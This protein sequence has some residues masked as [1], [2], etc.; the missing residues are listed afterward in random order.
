M[1]EENRFSSKQPE[2]MLQDNWNKDLLSNIKTMFKK[3]FTISILNKTEHTLPKPEFMFK[4]SPW[5]LDP[6]QKLKKKLNKVKSQLNNFNLG[7]WQQHTNRMNVAGDIVRTVK[8]NIQAELVTQAWCKF[9]EIA[10][11]FSLVPLN[12]VCCDVND[13]NFRSIHLCEAPGAFVTALNHWLKINA[14]DVKWDWLAVT[15]NPYCEGNPYG[16]MVADDRF[17]RHTLKHWYF[18]DDNTGDIMDVRNL[19]ALVKKFESLDRK[20]RTL[21]ITADG[22]ID[23]TD[24]PGEQESTVAQLHY[25]ETVACMHL[26]Q[27]GG[28]FLLKLFTLFEH[29][30]VC[31]MYLLS[32]VFHE[33]SVTKP[34]TSKGGNSEMYVVCINFK[35]REY[36]APYLPVLRD[37][38]S[39]AFPANAMFR[40]QDIPGD[41]LQRIYCC[42]NYFQQRQCEVIWDNI[43]TFRT[44]EDSSSKTPHIKRLISAK[45]IENCRL[46]KIDPANEIVGRELIERSSNQFVNKK[47]HVDSYN[48]RCKR[49]DLGSQERLL[50]IWDNVK[51][52]E[53]PAEKFF[54]LHLQAL[55]E[56][57][58]IQTGK[59]FNKIRSSRFCDSKILQ[60]LIEIDNVM[61]DMRTTI[62]FPSAEI[63][64]ELAQPIDLSYEILNFQFVQNYDSHQTITEIYYRLEKL[65]PE[66]TLIFIGYSLLTQLNVD[67]LYFLGNFFNKIIAEVHDNEGYRLKLE[68]YR[69]DEKALNY[70]REIMNASYDAHKKN[71]ALWSI[72]PITILYD[73]KHLW[74]LLILYVR[75]IILRNYI[76]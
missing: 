9:Y 53:W 35:G 16:H 41:F 40:L 30:S 8:E 48:E 76:K 37:Y 21:L 42:N 33:V 25:C 28:N 20:E 46:I 43:R 15:L 58:E 44:R 65:Q 69:R 49:Q 52:I 32:C 34:V 2:I 19:D 5:Q 71:M 12:N 7:K 68:T 57:F 4:E 51:E 10:S 27:K 64:K 66:Q 61:Q 17:I 70:L 6:L 18:G 11:T 31:L 50:Q 1:E 56:T 73:P 3:Q 63:T 62:S 55:P 39:N 22:S 23:C 74:D 38:Y 60:M 67:L 14:S 36:I 13:K 54:V 47:C 24:V 72:I 59:S 26:L 75:Q 45:Y 29:Q